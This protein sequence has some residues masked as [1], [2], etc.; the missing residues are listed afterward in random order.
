MNSS[1][2]VDG[3]G[4]PEIE[5]VSACPVFGRSRRAIEFEYMLDLEEHVS[6]RSALLWRGAMLQHI[7]RAKV[8]A[9][10]L[11]LCRRR[12]PHPSA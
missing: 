3:G 9:C 7:P 11:P 8:Q 6:G 1:Y 10:R 2:V 12:I 5:S 4:A